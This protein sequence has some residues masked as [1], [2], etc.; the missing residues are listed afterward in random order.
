MSDEDIDLLARLTAIEQ[1]LAFLM[2]KNLSVRSDSESEA[3]KATFFGHP[4]CLV[5]AFDG[6]D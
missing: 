1:T 6:L 2:A 3:V 5:P 4:S